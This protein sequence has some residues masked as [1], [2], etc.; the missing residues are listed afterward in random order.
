VAWGSRDVTTARTHAI[1]ALETFASID[2]RFN[3]GWASYTL[4]LAALSE[5]EAE[6]SDEQIR[7][8][9]QRLAEALRIFDEA[10]DVTGYSLVLDAYALLALQEG[11]RPRA[12]RLSG[13]VATL[14]RSSGTGLNS[15]NR[16]VLQ[17]D[18]SA[19]RDDP[20]L[21][22]AW[23]A[24]EKLSPSEAAAYALES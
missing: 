9:R 19:L 16:G 24:G 2:D 22:E 18:P 13:A 7:E 6:M 20:A 12:A 3:Y 1:R 14:E 10:Q 8:A 15:W 4:G 21:T 17:F 23:A 11:D 5:L